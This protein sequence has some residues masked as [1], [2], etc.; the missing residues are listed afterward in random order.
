MIETIEDTFGTYDH[1]GSQDY[2]DGESKGSGI[3]LA[4]V[5]KPSPR[6]HEFATPHEDEPEGNQENIKKPY[7]HSILD[8]YN[9]IVG[10]QLGQ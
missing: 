5:T 3:G 10:E 6:T 8:F 2:A 9:A 7:R 4:E 1:H